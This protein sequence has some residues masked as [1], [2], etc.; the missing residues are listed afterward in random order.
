MALLLAFAND[1]FARSQKPSTPGRAGA[2]SQR[3]AAPSQE[4]SAPYQR[5]TPEA[6]VVVKVSPGPE[7]E[8]KAAQDA[9]DRKE[10][11]ELDRKLVDFNGDLAFYTKLLAY[12]AAFQLMALLIQAYWL[13]R[14]VKVSEIAAI[15]AKESADAVVTQ[16]R[17]YAFVTA[18]N[19]R[20]FEQDGPLRLQIRIS[21]R[22]QTPAYE[23]THEHGFTY[24]LASISRLKG[25]LW[26]PERDVPLSK[27]TL[28]PGVIKDA[29]IDIAEPLSPEIK[30]AIRDGTHGL[31]AYGEIRY[32][33]GFGNPRVSKYRLMYGGGPPLIDGQFTVCEEGN[34]E[35]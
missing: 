26:P 2:Q 27:A 35:D 31:F 14:T 23:L 5:G 30:S 4:N 28:P 18:A 24:G 1:S 20:G 17:A 15:A 25:D 19:L 33:D 32:K 34:Y 6:P 22:G 10:K 11:A 7:D 9:K 3:Q 8:S 13:R 29:F 16:L 12:V 21:N